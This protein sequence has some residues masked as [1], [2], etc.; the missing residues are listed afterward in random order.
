MTLVRSS[1]CSREPGKRRQFE[2]YLK[3]EMSKPNVTDAFRIAVLDLRMADKLLANYLAERTRASLQ[4]SGDLKTRLRQTLGISKSEVPD[5]DLEAL[6][7]FFIA[8]NKISHEMDL[9]DPASDSIAREHRRPD[10]VAAQCAEAFKAGVGLIRGAA[11]ACK[12][13]GS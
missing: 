12:K 5:A 6:D 10:I 1:R 2:E 13:G 11:V 9:K 8:R 7:D 4:G 3:S